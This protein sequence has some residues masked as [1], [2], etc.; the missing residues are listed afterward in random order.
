MR[1]GGSGLVSTLHLSSSQRVYQPPTVKTDEE[2]LL[3]ETG[4]YWALWSVGSLW[5]WDAVS[6]LLSSDLLGMIVFLTLSV[7]ASH[8]KGSP[9]A[10]YAVIITRPKMRETVCTHAQHSSCLLC[11]KVRGARCV[12]KWCTWNNGRPLLIQVG[13][14]VACISALSCMCVFSHAYSVFLIYCDF[15]FL[16]DKS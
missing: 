16:R 15:T 2:S 7:L 6:A 5:L 1:G 9:G 8:F 3:Q 4:Q 14:M 12:D 13:P 10:H 11:H